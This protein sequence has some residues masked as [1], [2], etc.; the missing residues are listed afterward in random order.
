MMEIS[1]AN[2]KVNWIEAN[3][4]KSFHG[5]KQGVGKYINV[6]VKVRFCNIACEIPPPCSFN[7]TCF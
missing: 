1:E 5:R 3:V 7:E 6:L 4:D 2:L